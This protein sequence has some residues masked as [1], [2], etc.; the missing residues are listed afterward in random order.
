M[1]Q[2]CQSELI[3]QASIADVTGIR[4]LH[5]VLIPVDIKNPVQI[6]LDGPMS[7]HHRE[8]APVQMS[9]GLDTV[10]G[11]WTIGS[12]WNLGVGS[13]DRLDNALTLKA[14]YAF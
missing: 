11:A 6:I 14:R 7:A 8:D 1:F 5:A 13:H 2:H 9:L 3:E 12:E 4:G 10:T